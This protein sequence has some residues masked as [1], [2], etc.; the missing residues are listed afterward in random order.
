MMRRPSQPA[1]AMPTPAPR[2]AA[3]LIGEGITGK[4][5]MNGTQTHLEFI[6]EKHTDF[7]FAV[8]SEE[9]G[10]LGNVVLVFLYTLLIGR[11]LIIGPVVAPDA[12]GAKALIAHLVGLNA[13]KFVRID[14]D[15]AAH[16]VGG[17]VDLEQLGAVLVEARLLLQPRQR[18]LDGLQVGELTLDRAQVLGVLLEVTLDGRQPGPQVG[19]EWRQLGCR[20]Q[21]RAEQAL[22]PHQGP[23]AVDP[24]APAQLGHHHGDHGDG[25][26]R[27]LDAVLRV[28]QVLHAQRQ[29]HQVAESHQHPRRQGELQ[30][31]VL[32][33]QV[34]VQVKYSG[35]VE[36]QREDIEITLAEI[37]QHEA[38]CRRMLAGART[39]HSGEST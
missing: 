4:G 10:L 21:Q 12:E 39:T 15:F 29:Q 23:R 9:W 32:A 28:R 3:S 1:S 38:R 22:A 35:Y 34:E 19:G 6:P 26:R 13:G 5:F 14:I 27:G 8:Y 7:I 20:G 30:A 36:R 25:G 24:A 17:L 18:L 2:I 31:A 33:E 37:G 16:F 11:G